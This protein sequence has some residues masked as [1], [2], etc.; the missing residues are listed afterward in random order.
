MPYNLVQMQT[1]SFGTVLPA[2]QTTRRHIQST[3]ALTFTAVKRWSLPN[4]MAFYTCP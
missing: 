4:R 3:V 1:L 2:F